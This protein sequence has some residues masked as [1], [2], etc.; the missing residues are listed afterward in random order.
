M[1]VNWITRVNN[2][3]GNALGYDTMV[4]SLLKYSKGLIEHDE[5][6]PIAL[7]LCPA[8]FF[9]P[10]PGKYNV[11]FTMWESYCIP[12]VYKLAM[13]NADAVITPSRFCRD[14]FAPYCKRRPDVN[15]L[16]VNMNKYSYFKRE[17]PFLKKKPFRFMWCGAPNPRKGYP[18]ILEAVKIFK[19]VPNIEIYIKTTADSVDW[20]LIEKK[21]DEFKSDP[22]R[23]EAYDRI[24]EAKDK[25]KSYIKFGKHN[26]IIY[27]MRRLHPL[28]LIDLYK[29][30]HCFVLPN[31]G[32]GW[33]LT[34]SEAMATGAPCIATGKTGEMDFFNDNVG[35]T[36]KTDIKDLDLA[37]YN[38][39]SRVHVPDTKDFIDKMFYVMKHYGEA[40]RKG[41][42][43]SARIKNNFTW[44]KSAKRLHELLKGYENEINKANN[45]TGNITVSV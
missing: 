23:S 18:F 24:M 28:E 1:K 3:S 30:A 26:N 17:N 21:K 35:Y 44:E 42:K 27:D 29:S 15:W 20:N 12:S 25:L 13:M 16:G 43:A 31:M 9:D 19:N 6:S 32:E 10:I 40:F 37:N 14:V 11:L 2:L 22:E 5:N 39:K 45:I 33:G 7:Q 36:I 8:E 34:L 4:S 41:Q 38:L